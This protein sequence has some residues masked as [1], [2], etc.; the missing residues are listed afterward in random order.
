MR[1]VYEAVA[2]VWCC[3]VQQKYMGGQTRA[4]VGAG[5]QPQ[6]RLARHAGLVGRRHS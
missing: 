2:G 4:I 1:G 6:D 5:E 3:A